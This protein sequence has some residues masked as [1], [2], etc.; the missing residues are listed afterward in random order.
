MAWTKT[1]KMSSQGLCP[2]SA[3]SPAQANRATARI[4]ST[5]VSRSAVRVVRRLPDLGVRRKTPS[6][7]A[8]PSMQPSAMTQVTERLMTSESS[9]RRYD[10]VVHWRS[11]NS[12]H[13][14]A[15]MMNDS[16]S[17][18]RVP[19]IGATAKPES[20]TSRPV[21]T[22]SSRLKASMTRSRNHEREAIR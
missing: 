3:S 22:N 21:I 6:L 5:R 12:M 1:R 8:T 19:S 18:D 16:G 10:K 20:D 11:V 17:T 2:K 4:V 14:V 9:A 13:A 7:R 15:I